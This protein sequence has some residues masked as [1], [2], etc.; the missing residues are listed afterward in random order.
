MK[1]Q[2]GG[3][4]VPN[5]LILR[6]GLFFAAVSLIWFGAKTPAVA[7]SSS[8]GI[9]MIPVTLAMPELNLT[10]PQGTTNVLEV[11][12]NLTAWQEV[13][14]LIFTNANL[15]WV[16]LNLRGG[17][18]YRLRRVFN[19]GNQPPFPAPLTNLVWIPPGQFIMGSPE[20]D[21][22]A[23]GDEAP[24]TTVTLTKG[25]FIGKYEVTQGEYL[26]VTGTNP[27]SFTG[28]TNLPV[29]TVSW[30]NATNFCR[31][32]NLREA[33]VGRLPSGY[34]YRLPT[35][36]E[37]EYAARAGSANRF[38]WGNDNNYAALPN[39][40]WFSDNSGG[41]THPVGEKQ[42]NSFGL[43]DVS[44]NVCEWCLDAFAFY[45]GS[46]VTDPAPV[47]GANKIF[48]GGSHGDAAASC[49]PADRRDI[50]LTTPPLD[51]FGFRVVLAQNP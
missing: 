1:T 31:L 12:T 22:D 10:A 49:R 6:R 25:F 24:Q 28:D 43:Y 41:G 42:P 35:E 8:L 51:I 16:D 36:A 45:S 14:T 4:G 30:A 21:S 2:H 50:P 7:Q 27:S 19:G 48:R 11:S 17:G 29:D 39:Y 46:E 20:T 13:T 15:T 38:S 47:A 34:A 18:Y 26:A 37:W 9:K 33:G 40:A 44:G 5:L 23:E 32:L 3:F